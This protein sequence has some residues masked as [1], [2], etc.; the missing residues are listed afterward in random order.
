MSRGF[1][2][3][4]P[5]MFAEGSFAPREGVFIGELIGAQLYWS[6]NFNAPKD[7][8]ISIREGCDLNIGFIFA[9][10][11]PDS[12]NTPMENDAEGRYQHIE[13]FVRLQIDKDG[14]FGPGGSRAKANKI[15]TGLYGE[16]FD[17]FD[18]N[19]EFALYAPELEQYNDI[20]EVPHYQEYDKGEEWLKLTELSINGQN[21]IG[22]RTQLQ[23]GHADKPDGGK[24]DKVTII[25]A[26]PM[27]KTGSRKKAPLKSG[28][29]KKG[30]NGN[31]AGDVTEDPF[32]KEAAPVRTEPRV[33]T[34]AL[35][36]HIRWVIARMTTPPLSIQEKD[37]LPFLQH[38][39]EDAVGGPIA[40]LED[41]DRV[42]AK[43]FKGLYEADGGEQLAEMY[44]EWAKARALSGKAEVADVTSDDDEFGEDELPF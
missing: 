33:D 43:S 36:Q 11:D 28:A 27:P 7:A 3:R 40:A 9:I 12:E 1:K 16:S 21:L 14:N 5:K 24:S 34:S 30:E 32:E 4:A 23:F 22:K 17:A 19:F 26:M 20:Y 25:H 44:Q 39:T 42:D 15:M 37:W 8:D 10:E 29:A 18:E 2:S 31:G 41:L 35:P 13:G 6:T 38:F